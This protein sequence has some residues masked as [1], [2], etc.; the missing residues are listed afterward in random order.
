LDHKDENQD[1]VFVVLV[2]C[3]LANSPQSFRR[4]SESSQA[5]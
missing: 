5:A 2:I 3:V 1:D 4:R